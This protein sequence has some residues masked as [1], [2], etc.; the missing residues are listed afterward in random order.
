MANGESEGSLYTASIFACTDLDDRC[1]LIR[2]GFTFYIFFVFGD[3]YE[4]P[5]QMR[6]IYTGWSMG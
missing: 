3:I 5:L 4:N 6:D 1:F 2:G